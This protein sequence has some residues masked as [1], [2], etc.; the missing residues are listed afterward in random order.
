MARAPRPERRSTRDRI[1][2]SAIALF[3]EHGV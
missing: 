3:N 2:D 1:V